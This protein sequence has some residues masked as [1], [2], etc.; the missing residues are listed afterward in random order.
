MFK[1]LRFI[2]GLWSPSFLLTRK[3]LLINFHFWGK[4]HWIATFFSPKVLST[5]FIFTW[6]ESEFWLGNFEN[7]SSRLETNCRTFGFLL[8]FADFFTKYCKKVFLDMEI[9]YPLYPVVHRDLCQESLSELLSKRF[10]WSKE[11][12]LQDFLPVKPQTLPL[13]SWK[14]TSYLLVNM[15]VRVLVFLEHSRSL[16]SISIIFR[17]FC[18]AFLII[19]STPSSKVSFFSQ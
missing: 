11:F 2:T 12:S 4:V 15:A 9:C 8:L 7:L 18:W 5:W 6:R 13:F 17:A 10:C 19:S 1:L 14:C 3:R 16:N